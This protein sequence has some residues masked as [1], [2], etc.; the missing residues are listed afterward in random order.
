MGSQLASAEYS[1]EGTICGLLRVVSRGSGQEQR[2]PLRG[3]RDGVLGLRQLARHT[4]LGDVRDDGG[5][6]GSGDADEDERAVARGVLFRLQRGVLGAYRAF[7]DPQSV[8]HSHGRQASVPGGQGARSTTGGP[9]LYI[10]VQGC[11]LRFTGR[12]QP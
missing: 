9:P 3:E 12:A 7:M 10:G 5:V 1:P 8:E 4:G 2:Q 11:G 6:E